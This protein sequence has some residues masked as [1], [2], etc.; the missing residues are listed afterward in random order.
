MVFALA[1]LILAVPAFA[2]GEAPTE[3][4]LNAAKFMTKCGKCHT[5]GQGD[6]VGPDLKGVLTRR[7]RQWLIGFI[8]KPS[9]YFEKDP[10][11]KE[12]LE[13][14]NGVKMDDLGLS[15]AEAEGMLDFIEAASAGPVGPK[16]PTALIPEDPYHKLA[17]PDEGSDVFTPGAAASAMFLI[18]SALLWQ[19]GAKRGASMLILLSFGIGYWSW[20]GRKHYRLLGN[21]QSYSPQQ[22]IP[23]SHKQ[24]AGEMRI[25]CMY[26]HHGAEKSDVAG[27]PSLDICMNCHKAVKKV[28][29]EPSPEIAKLASIWDSR[30]DAEPKSLEWIRVHRLPDY[31]HFSHKAHVKNNIQCQECHGPVQEMTTMRQSSSLAMGWCVNCHRKQPGEAPTHWKRSTGS[32]DCATCHW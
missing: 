9:D 3:F 13:K 14:F 20:G 32:L 29:N 17:V 22:P 1:F 27:V 8:Q 26:C 6:R 28:G 4:Q 10:V 31:V 2:F 30:S 12:L 21:Q 15:R 18:L 24:H 25:A 11:A 16:E 7:D 23:F 19:M 5:V